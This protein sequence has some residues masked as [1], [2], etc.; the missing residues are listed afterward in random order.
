MAQARVV[1]LNEVKK[2]NESGWQI[3]FQYCRYEYGNED[4]DQENGYR[5]MWRKPNGHL[6]PARGGARIPSVAH[7]LELSSMAIMQ[8]WGHHLNGTDGFSVEED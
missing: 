8:G 1:V 6:Q 5:F 3:C 7:V 4:G 2:T